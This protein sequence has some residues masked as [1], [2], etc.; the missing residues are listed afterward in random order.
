[1]NRVV[2]RAPRKAAAA[3]IPGT[4]GSSVAAAMTKKPA[5]EFTPITL[6]LAMALFSTP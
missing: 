4:P 2:S 3:M 1:M 5:P 6:G